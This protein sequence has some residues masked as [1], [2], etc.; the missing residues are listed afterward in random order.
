MNIFSKLFS[1][2][3]LLS[4]LLASPI[5][6]ASEKISQSLSADD[7]TNISV[8][9]HSGSIKV[10]GWNK[11]KVSI[12]GTLDEKAEN[13]VFKQRGAQIVIEVE[14]PNIERW[15]SSGSELIIHAPKDLRLTLSGI[16]SDIDISNLHGGI[17]AK[18]VSG[19]IEA[20]DI[21]NN[22]EL[23]SISGDITSRDLN[24]KISLSAVSGD[25]NDKNSSGRLQL[26][27]VSGEV[28]LSSQATE[29]F[30]NN[31]SGDVELDLAEVIELRASTVSGDIESKLSL[32]DKGL[33]KASSVSGEL[34]FVFQNDVDASF[35]LKSNVGGD[36]VNKLSND[37]AERPKYGPGAK[38][39]FQTGN[40]NAT[41]SANSVSGIIKLVAK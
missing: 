1:P 29:V 30:V 16:S 24:G 11:N 33:I 22:I 10:V 37:K 3:I 26:Q 28:E 9:N 36:I 12:E 23:S 20:V 15:S 25:I 39:F 14:Y 6:L 4:S 34:A 38:L 17:E 40:G 2:A 8:D 31:V 19:N 21:T 18:T 7:V 41:V 32:T 35:R 27:S 5:S 13:L